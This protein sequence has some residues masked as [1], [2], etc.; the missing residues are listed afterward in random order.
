MQ[1]APCWL[2][3]SISLRSALSHEIVK[4]STKKPCCS[5][6]VKFSRLLSKSTVIISSSVPIHQV[7]R[8][9]TGEA[10]IIRQHVVLPHM[11]DALLQ[12]D[13]EPRHQMP[14]E[15]SSLTTQP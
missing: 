9:T 15:R 2:I 3:L 8:N 7:L 14:K 12:K 6:G 10:D 4:P 11:R 1:S 5:T 13:R